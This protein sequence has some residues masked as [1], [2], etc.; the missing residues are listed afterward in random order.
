[1]NELDD[2]NIVR[3][4][5]SVFIGQ[6]LTFFAIFYGIRAE[7]DYFVELFSFSVILSILLFSM[8]AYVFN[9]WISAIFSSS[10]SFVTSFAPVYFVF[11]EL[12]EYNLLENYSCLLFTVPFVYFLMFLIF[13]FLEISNSTYTEISGNQELKAIIKG[14]S[15]KNK[16]RYIDYKI[17]LRELKRRKSKLEKE[18]QLANN[19]KWKTQEIERIKNI[20]KEIL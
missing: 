18:E 5:V 6:F 19:L 13:L 7:I 17:A 8:C 9:N 4:M 16:V 20:K 14:M 3:L 12:Q 2:E 11:Y 1:M 10:M 15:L